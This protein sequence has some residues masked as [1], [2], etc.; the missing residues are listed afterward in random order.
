MSLLEKKQT[1]IQYLNRAFDA[2]TDGIYTV[3]CKSGCAFC[4]TRD[5][6]VT[7][8]EAYQVHKQLKRI[9]REW[10]HPKAAD[11]SLFRPTYT[12]NDFAAACYEHRDLA[13][14]NPGPEI[15]ACPL[16]ENGR[17]SVYDSRP[18]ACRAFL[19]LKHCRLTDQAEIPSGLASVIGACQQII[20]HI[21][22]RGYYGNLLD[23]LLI[24]D[25]DDPGP[26]YVRDGYMGF[27][28]MPAAKP[29]PGFLIPPEDREKVNA[30]LSRLFNIKIDGISFLE[31]C[32]A[33]R[34]MPFDKK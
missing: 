6:T 30:F 31:L 11:P 33:L 32:S 5:V 19:S 26:G 9:G 12:T 28:G 18:F 3:A 23:M 14:E 27:T 15:S 8:L 2:H 16:L 22:V 17:C 1:L 10:V 20:E 4:C 29:L 7:T 34:P 24:L 21:D 13:E 25:R